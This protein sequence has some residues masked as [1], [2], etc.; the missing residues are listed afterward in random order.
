[1]TRSPA[2][3][4]LLSCAVTAGFLAP[5]S[6][7]STHPSLRPRSPP[8][9]L[10]VPAALAPLAGVGV[11]AGV[12]VGHE[13]GHFTAARWLGIRVKEFSV[14]FGP[15]LLQIPG[16]T[17]DDPGLAVRA[18]PIG[19][20][21]SF[22]RYINTTALEA[23]GIPVP[24]EA[25]KDP[26][27]PL[28][29][30]LLENRNFAQQALVLVAGVAANVALAFTLL[31]SSG[32]T[33]GVPLP[34]ET[35]PV[36]I[37]RVEPRSPA[38]LA[39]MKGGDTLVRVGGGKALDA[40]GQLTPL[41]SSLRQIETLKRQRKPFS[42][43]VDRAGERI[44]LSVPRVSPDAMLGIELESPKVKGSIRR[45]PPLQM[46]A[47]ASERVTSALRA[48]S[49]AIGSSARALVS[50]KPSGMELQGP[51]GVAS[52]ASALASSRPS[53]LFEFA[54]FLSLNLAVFNALPIP[55]LD[56]WQLLVLSA[57]KLSRRKLPDGA[58][59]AASALTSLL[60]LWVFLRVLLGDVV[61]ATGASLPAVDKSMLGVFF[62]LAAATVGALARGPAA[63]DEVDA[64]RAPAAEPRPWW[65]GGAQQQSRPSSQQQRR[66]QQQRQQ[67]RRSPKSPKRP[68]GGSAK[69]PN[70][71]PWWGAKPK[72]GGQGGNSDG[73][74][75]WWRG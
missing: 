56:G 53:L 59:E 61:A 60:L 13:L 62:G 8:P 71:W 32:L 17:D 70:T 72:G 31:F 45:P 14:G 34:D 41:S 48:I 6:V 22:P 47:I 19:G 63:D 54:A 43:T 27:D 30:D 44:T 74:G 21:V 65:A 51:V 57:E 35:P 15:P 68:A 7:V 73:A 23:R 46:A 10:A 9:A 33:V 24:S 55:G 49:Y 26:V 28:D 69:P 58:K 66:L 5:A 11:L 36:I 12:I 37:R 38:A 42:A 20:Y 50:G 67:L 75:R 25:V 16:R 39:G 29:P 3:V 52:T 18:L 1:M 40:D 2:L 64:R 4:V